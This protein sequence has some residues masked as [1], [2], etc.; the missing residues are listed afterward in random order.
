MQRL[1]LLSF[2][3]LAGSPSAQTLDRIQKTGEF[4]IAHRESSVPF[5]YLLPGKAEPVGLA[6]DLCLRVARAVERELKLPKLKIVYVPVSSSTRIPA[7]QED[8]ADI[9][10]GSTTDN[11]QRREQVAFSHHHFFAAVQFLARSGGPRDWASLD[12]KTLAYTAGTS[13]RK[14]VES[15]PATRDLKVKVLEGKDHAESFALLRDGKVDAFV[16]EDVLLPAQRAGSGK[17]AGF[18]V[19]GRRLTIEPY[20]LMMRKGDAAFQRLVNRE[21]EVAFT[22]GDYAK[23]YERWFQKPI[24]PN[25]VQLDLP[26]SRLLRDQMRKPSSIIPG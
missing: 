5:S 20:A 15:D 24:P 19:G 1:L 21:L 14:V 23:L 18:A 22:S 13:T 11:L 3:L 10:C 17:P 4:R 12:G 9:E 6:V 7:I 8:K 25:Q 2:A 26:P 16:L